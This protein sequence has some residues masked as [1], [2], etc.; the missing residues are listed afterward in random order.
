M[1][2]D[3][4][5]DTTWTEPSAASPATTLRVRCCGFARPQGVFVLT[6]FGLLAGAVLACFWAGKTFE[7]PLAIAFCALF[8]HA[9]RLDRSIVSA[10]PAEFSW[11]VCVSASLGLFSTGLL[12]H[13][14]PHRSFRKDLIVEASVL[15][16]LVPIV[17]RRILRFL[18]AQQKLV[19]GLLVVGTGDLAAKLVRDM[20]GHASAVKSYARSEVAVDFPR[21]REMVEQGRISR[22]IVAERDD[23]SRIKLAAALVDLR[24]RG[25]HVEDAIDFY[26]QSFQR[27]WVDALRSE[28]VVY[29]DGF[30][31]SPVRLFFKR[32]IDVVLALILL[33]AMLPLMALVA[34]AIEL[35][36]KGGILFRQ[37]RV[38]LHGA[39]FT[40][41]K[42]RS[43][44]Q[45]A[46][47]AGG[48]AWATAADSRVTRVGRWLRKFRLDEI[49]QAINVLRGE[50]S[51]VGPRPER[52]YF[53]DR[54]TQEIPFYGLRHYIKPGLTGWAQVKYPYGACIEDALQ[55]LQYDLY[56]AKHTSF[57]FDLNIL[58]R[59][60]KIVLIGRGW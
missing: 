46:E 8:F 28:W 32:L 30:R 44:R 19:E 21:L 29:T 26:E 6:E 27:I 1:H 12:F 9:S 4:I 38:G 55:K 37:A 24:L 36:S 7:A 13:L 18:I 5:N 20:E 57:A 31:H 56:Y 33:V 52:P 14:F 23:E 59:T 22:V 3:I 34:I 53:V 25:V 42:F 17:L 45:D 47:V 10:R 16:S 15:A 11:R 58:L 50:M 39:T 40:A 51:F 49:P 35:D 2:T 60:V 54:L 43:M 41:L 48:P